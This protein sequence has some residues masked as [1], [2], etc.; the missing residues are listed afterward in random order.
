MASGIIKSYTRPSGS[1]GEGAHWSFEWTSTKKSAGVSTVSWSL[2][3]RGRTSSPTWLE[4]GCWLTVGKNGTTTQ[5]YAKE[6]TSGA[7]CSFSDK[8]RASGSFDVTHTA[9]GY[10]S[11]TVNFEVYIY[12]YAHKTNSV[13][14]VLDTLP[15]SKPVVTGSVADTNSKTINLTG[16]SSKL[17]KF[18]SNATATMTA[19]G[20]NGAALDEDM[21]IIRN[22][23]RTGYG[24][25]HTF[26]NVESNVFTFS[27]ED[28]HG[29]VG[30]AEVKATMIPYV[31]LTCNMS[32]NKPD[33]DGDMSVACYGNFFNDSFGAVNNTL[34]VQYRYKVSGGS[35][36]VWNDMTVTKSGNSYY[37]SAHLEG[38]DYQKAYVFECQAIDQLASVS[39]GDTPVISKPVFHWSKN[40]FTFEV[41][42][43][44]NGGVVMP[45]AIG[46]DSG[47][48]TIPSDLRLK[49]DG[50]YGNKLL[51]GDGEYCYISE[52]TDDSMTIHASKIT[53]DASSGVYHGGYALPI[54]RYGIWT[55]SLNSSVVSSYTTQYGWYSKVNQAVTVGFI[56]KA[57]CRSGYD[58][59]SISISG[60]P[61]TPMFSAAGG[62]MCSG[63]Y[64]GGGFTFQCFVAETS[65]SITTRV[66][67]CNNTSAT[68]LSTS[69]SGCNYRSGGG[70]ITLSGTITY[71][72]NS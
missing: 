6:H 26:N 2:Y 10:A 62:G 35:F 19:K 63:A 38:L 37:A 13:T 16:D 36:G 9:S 14:A 25:S 51:F 53:L 17:V 72:S 60:L 20:Q 55:P 7:D 69:A 59:T 21:Y 49:G 12:E 33:G 61:F 47:E 40:D 57:T 66:Q 50:N 18:Y 34:T 44:F 46:D 56:I 45:A 67:A 8:F 32:N 1:Y 41:P 52:P 22:G 11:F 15:A 64:V 4:T 28:E 43:T 70:E 71:M 27:A 31:K 29:N 58:N 3:T 39:S 30:T 48:M 24:K 5:I 23:N 68:N 65:G 42:V 54:V